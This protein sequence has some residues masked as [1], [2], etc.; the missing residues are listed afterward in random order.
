[1]K[2][3]LIILFVC[4]VCVFFCCR[5]QKQK[6]I[7]I[8]AMQKITTNRHIGLIANICDTVVNCA[9]DNGMP[10]TTIDST[11]FFS[12]FDTN[13]FQLKDFFHPINRYRYEGEI[14]IKINDSI[15]KINQFVV[16]PFR[17]MGADSLQAII[18]YDVLRHY[19]LK[20]DFVN[21]TFDLSN[22]YSDSGYVKLPLISERRLM[23]SKNTMEYK[24]FNANTYCNSK[25]KEGKFWF[26]LGC[27]GDVAGVFKQKF[28]SDLKNEATIIDS[29]VAQGSSFFPTKAYKFRIDSIT[30]SGFCASNITIG[31]ILD[32]DDSFYDKD[33]EDGLLGWQLFK[34]CEIIVDWKKDILL[35]KQIKKE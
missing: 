16:R 7:E 31:T 3:K 30:I 6:G 18:G 4:I 19:I 8:D 1:M 13:M 22:N 33:T 32:Q 24:Y 5:R 25:T 27:G 12:Y 34:G 14:C 10:L 21:N 9:M 35:V 17:Q 23:R 15:C 26:D 20:I 11:F 29:V 28:F 2:T